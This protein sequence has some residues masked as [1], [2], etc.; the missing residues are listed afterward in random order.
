MFFAGEEEGKP[1]FAM[2]FVEGES[3]AQMLALRAP[4]SAA[5][6]ARIVV[7]AARGL[8]AAHDKGII[9]R[10]IKP[11]NLL[12][13]GELVKLTDFGIAYAEQ[14]GNKLTGT[15]EFVGT[16]GY[17]SPEVC[18]ASEVDAR[19]DIFS[20]GIVY[21]EM[22]AGRMPF[23]NPSPLG[24]ML[25][26]VEA[27]IPD[28]RSLNP[29]VDVH[30]FEILSR[31]VR[32]NPED[33]YAD[34]REL[35]RDLEEGL[36]H[37]HF[38]ETAGEVTPLLSA[39]QSDATVAVPTP[40]TMP[41]PVADVGVVSPT[42]ATDP[43]LV[44]G[45]SR[46]HQLR[47]A[48]VLFAGVA[49]LLGCAYAAWNADWSKLREVYAAVVTDGSGSVPAAE[50]V[51]QQVV[52][53]ADG[54]LAE[55]VDS[56]QSQ[57]TAQRSD[58]EPAG[59]VGEA[60]VE[61][62]QVAAPVAAEQL[63]HPVAREKVAL[64]TTSPETSARSSL[65]VGTLPAG[66][67]STVVPDSQAIPEG[68]RPR[69][70]RRP[71]LAA[72][73]KAVANAK[74]VRREGKQAKAQ[75]LARLENGTARATILVVGDSPLVEVVRTE[76]ESAVRE[77]GV[78]VLDSQFIP[79]LRGVPRELPALRH[80]LLNS[81]TDILVLVRLAYSG[82]QMLEYYGEVSRLVTEQMNVTAYVLADRHRLGAWNEAVSYTSLNLQLKAEEA[83]DAIAF[84]LQRELSTVIQAAA[85]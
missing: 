24:L 15:G 23:D 29:G 53:V 54:T 70:V 48:A 1:F 41:Q 58:Y 52:K 63:E 30:S 6:S 9:H 47:N 38:S 66:G 22:L 62:E 79:G 3:L 43:T 37:G 25:E 8:A 14:F 85:G 16:P 4:L 36:Q 17:L 26:V 65:Q 72:A 10:D 19:S 82:D 59:G 7:Q 2:E 61:P 49:L 44:V 75:S 35:I 11:G 39:S 5:E 13:S 68:N 51:G 21:F 77:A 80:H 55:A 81:S 33:R 69:S 73:R 20:L 64:S 67:T 34:C 31:M 50:P 18:T 74:S 56:L 78:E 32:K 76:F 27:K 12:L 46:S 28:I 45:G 84:Q 71:V 60:P 83:V 42:A 40:K 57:S